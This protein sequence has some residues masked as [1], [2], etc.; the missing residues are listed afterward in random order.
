MTEKLYDKDAYVKTFTARVTGCEE[1]DGKYEVCLDKTAFFPKEGGQTPDEGTLNKKKVLSVELMKD[2]IIHIV[3]SPFNVGDEV[4][5]EIDWNH[6]YKNMQMHSGEHVFSGLVYKNYGYNNVGF[7][8]SDTSAT[9]DYDGKLTVKEVRKLELLANKAIWAGSE[10]KTFFPSEDELERL[11]YRSKSGIK[12]KV[13]IVEIEGIDLCAC[14]AP[15]VR[16]IYEVGMLRII[17]VENYKGGVRLNYLCGERALLDYIEISN[18]RDELSQL[19]NVKKE[20]I[21]S[22][23]ERLLS[24][25]Q[26]LEYKIGNMERKNIENMVQSLNEP[27]L[28]LYSVNGDLLKFSMALLRKCFSRTCYVFSGDDEN[29]YRYLVESDDEDL[30]L[31]NAKLK[32]KLAAKGGGKKNSIQGSVNCNRDEIV[33]ILRL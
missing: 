23:C 13:R 30:M 28:F 5:G 32:E 33:A 1:K 14:C 20:N 15:H 16:N 17:S 19:L 26:E 22:S 4:T 10:I 18:E 3:E 6:R 8:L 25:K 27:I 31:L 2:E 29:G 7:H 11:S 24:E 12:G 21:K 9:M